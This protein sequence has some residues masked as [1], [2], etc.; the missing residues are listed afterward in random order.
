MKQVRKINPDDLKTAE[1]QL[2]SLSDLLNEIKSKPDK[3]PDDIE[4]LANLGLQLKEISQHLDD[5]KMILDVT[6]SRKAR[7]FYENVKKLAKEGDKNAE[8]IY[9]DL[10]EDF[11]KFDVN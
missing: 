7:A 9:N 11:E 6:L 4:L 1:E 10:K 8:K 3:T 2:L 5:I